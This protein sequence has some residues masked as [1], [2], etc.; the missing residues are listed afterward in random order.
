MLLNTTPLL[1][2]LVGWVQFW[3]QG[4]VGTPLLLED[5]IMEVKVTEKVSETEL[6]VKVVPWLWSQ[7]DF[8]EKTRGKTQGIMD[9]IW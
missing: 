7:V 8:L 6:K 2:W 4:V 3:I 9:K 1:S 5:G